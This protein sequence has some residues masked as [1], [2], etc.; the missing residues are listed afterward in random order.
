MRNLIMHFKFD[1][2]MLFTIV[3]IKIDKNEQ[4]RFYQI[5]E[6][7]AFIPLNKFFHSLS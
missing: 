5:G 1:L 4:L 3:L 2:N 7:K 6:G